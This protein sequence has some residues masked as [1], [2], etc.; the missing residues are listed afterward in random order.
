MNRKK[1]LICC[2]SQFGYHIDTYYYSKYL[3]NEFQV[4]YVCWDYNKEKHKIDGV[5]VHYVSRSGNIFLRNIRYL[6]F[7]LCLIRKENFD[8]TFI[9][10]FKFCFILS[11]LSG[12]TKFIFDIRTAAV[13]ENFF[14]RI[15][16]DLLLKFEAKFF[17]RKTIISKSLAQKLG[18]KEDEIFILPLGADPI[19]AKKNTIANIDCNKINLIYVGT[20]IGRN[21][22]NTILGLKIFSDR[23]PEYKISYTIIGSGRRGEIEAIE[24]VIEK[25]N[26][27]QFVKMLGFIPHRELNQHFLESDVGVAYVPITDYYNVQPSTKVYE[28]VVSKI[29]VIATKTT[30]NINV[31]DASFGVLTGDRP[32]DFAEGIQTIVKKINEGK[33]YFDEQ[34]ISKFHWD[35]VVGELIKYLRLNE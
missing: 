21:I 32:A 3:K 15:C 22:Q 10:Y 31:L 14:I 20:F 13:N 19:S 16:E 8:F 27:R 7:L 17:S 34:T 4:T 25:S 33:I 9:K 11:L 23:N 26:L 6:N 30:E 12:N 35:N 18:L 28:Y 24:N 2:Q 5:D 29:P 1:I